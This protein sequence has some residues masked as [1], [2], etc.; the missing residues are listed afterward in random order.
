VKS[1]RLAVIV[2]LLAAVPAIAGGRIKAQFGIH[3][4]FIRFVIESQ[5][6]VTARCSIDAGRSTVTI[7][8]AGADV[9]ALPKQFPRAS[10]IS[11]IKITPIAKD[12]ARIIVSFDH[13]VG[14]RQLTPFPP[15]DGFAFRTVLDFP[16][17]SPP[18]AP[19]SEA[20]SPVPASPVVAPPDMAPPE[21]APAAAADTPA[22]PAPSPRQIGIFS[23]RTSFLPPGTQQSELEELVRQEWGPNQGMV[24]MKLAVPGGR[25]QSIL[26]LPIN[27]AMLGPI[28]LM[29]RLSDAD[30]SLQETRL[31]WTAASQSGRTTRDV[32]QILTQQATAA[33]FRSANTA[34]PPASDEGFYAAGVL[35]DSAGRSVELM[36]LPDS[37]DNPRPALVRALLSPA[38]QGARQ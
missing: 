7:V 16:D 6:M 37:L 4:R 22:A 20:A 13:P 24:R 35:A 38:G 8:L 2:C 10:G 36:F 12:K 31:E 23:A 34:T 25:T 9:A 1:I 21:M 32:L 15:K 33:G 26:L 3:D 18:A 29:F 11:A 14:L 19:A 17:M 28:H 5:A 30:G 27:D